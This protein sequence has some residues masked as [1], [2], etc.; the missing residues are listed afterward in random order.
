M[1]STTMPSISSKLSSRIQ[2]IEENHIFHC[3]STM[4]RQEEQYIC[5][6]YLEDAQSLFRGDYSGDLDNSIIDETCRSKMCEWIF[7]VIDST[8][9]QRETA[10]VAMNFLDRF[11]CASTQRAERARTNRSEYQLAGEFR[12]H[13]YFIKV[14][15]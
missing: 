4:L 5:H 9:L 10:S 6:D 3:I 2:G 14:E 13:Y 12:V 8:R 11:L 7:H 1:E 15:L